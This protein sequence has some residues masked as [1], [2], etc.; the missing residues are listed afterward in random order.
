MRVTPWGKH[1]TDHPIRIRK[2][3]KSFDTTQGSLCVMKPGYRG[4]L[5]ALG[6][7]SAGHQE[8][9]GVLGWGAALWGKALEPWWA[10]S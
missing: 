8:R 7:M 6:R 1:V 5:L 4:G 9:P 3:M 10:V 2:W